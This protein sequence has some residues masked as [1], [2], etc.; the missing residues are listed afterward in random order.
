MCKWQKY[1]ALEAEGTWSSVADVQ[2]RSLHLG[3]VSQYK[4]QA[5]ITFLMHLNVTKA[6]QPGVLS[7]A[8]IPLPGP[9]ADQG[10]MYRITAWINVPAGGGLRDNNS[11][12]TK[13]H[14]SLIGAFN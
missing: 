11:E 12:V 5:L 2:P 8:L 1:L 9:G 3:C 13:T 6:P 7:K 4:G 14:P 10:C